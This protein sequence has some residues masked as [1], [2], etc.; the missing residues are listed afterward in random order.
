[1]QLPNDTFYNTGIATYVWI[2][3]KDK[4]EERTGKVQLIDASSCYTSRRKNIGN[5]RV[6][7]TTA[8]RDLIVK[9]YG[10]YTDGTFKDVDENG[11]EITDERGVVKCTPVLDE[12]GNQIIDYCGGIDLDSHELRALNEDVAPFLNELNDAFE[13]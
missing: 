1:V 5:K 7:I 10:D 4:P 3:T 11:N 8:C 12:K 13:V 6:D 9:I 2:I